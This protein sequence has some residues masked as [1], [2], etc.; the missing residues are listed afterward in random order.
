MN[1]TIQPSS[2]LLERH[3]DLFDDRSLLVFGQVL[4]H[5]PLSLTKSCKQLQVHN[6]NFSNHQ[7]MQAKASDA[8]LSFG[9]LPKAAEGCNAALMYMPKAKQEAAMLLAAV[10]PQL[11]TGSE[12]Y[13]VGENRGGINATDK[14]LKHYGLSPRKLDSARRC[15]L[16]YCEIDQPIPAFELQQWQ[17]QFNLTLPQG[18][19]A[20]SSMPG[21]FNHGKLDAGTEL[22]LQ[23]L[24]KLQGEILDFG[25]GVGVIGAAL[26]LNK[27]STISMLDVSA[28]AVEC[29][30][31]SLTL[32]GLTG[33][34]FA[35]DG[36]SEVTGRYDFIVSNPPFHTGVH[37]DYQVVENFIRGVKK[38]LK[39]QGELWLVANS[40]LQYESLLNSNFSSWEQRVDNRK[41]KVL[42]AINN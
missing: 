17:Q 2:Q 3:P 40:H 29:A 34:V 38:H 19:V 14:L 1:S 28:Y 24:P 37:T 10:L 7:A 21:V 26:A 4:D 12:L 23:Q 20:L 31:Q 16:Y 33:T 25:C 41:F 36:L 27:G 11:P 39:P 32:N 35:S 8:Q 30:R 13:V 9:A 22:L 18:E 6:Y 15:S 5:Y 42:R